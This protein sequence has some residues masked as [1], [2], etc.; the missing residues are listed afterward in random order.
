MSVEMDTRKFM[1][2]GG[3]TDHFEEVF[4]YAA[5]IFCLD[6]EDTV[7]AERK[8]A[9]RHA[10]REFIALGAKRGRRTAIRVS[11]LSSADGLR[12]LLLMQEQ[13][14][15]PEMVVLAKAESP[16]EVALVR[17]LLAPKLGDF[18]LQPIIET[19]H[20]LSQVEQIASV[21]GVGSISLGGKDL[22]ESLR[23]EREWEPLLYARSRSSA[24]AAIA[25]IPIVDGP[26]PK[27]TTAQDLRLL[28]SKLKA[29][30]F[31]GKSAIF[32][33]QL[34]VIN[35]VWGRADAHG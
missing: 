18:H 20:A 27:D 31:A 6:L 11:A 25:G 1:V 15:A 24:A 16:Q 7:P 22:S 3:R 23:V 21:A 29:L 19:A 32:P 9:A 4:G 5:D 13:P 34:D 33:E 17:Q 26:Q 28:C 30:G 35:E 2:I 8:E 12:D 10:V 14:H